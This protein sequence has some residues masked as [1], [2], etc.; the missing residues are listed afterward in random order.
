MD[1]A[2]MS[3]A[4]I[5]NFVPKEQRET[6]SKSS[7]EQALVFRASMRMLPPISIDTRPNQGAP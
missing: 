1:A 4:T 5:R 3:G 6:P 7:A 2:S